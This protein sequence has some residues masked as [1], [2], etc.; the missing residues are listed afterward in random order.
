MK[1]GC[2]ETHGTIIF[3]DDIGKLITDCTAPYE[4]NEKLLLVI[5]PDLIKLPEQI[6][7]YIRTDQKYMFKIV[8]TIIS[9]ESSES[10]PVA[11]N[12]L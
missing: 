7:K 8:K 2:M 12:R 9:G 3:T 6:V 4:M 1:S 5:G 10:Y 11:D